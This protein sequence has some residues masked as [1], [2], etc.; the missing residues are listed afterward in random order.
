M[1]FFCFTIIIIIVFLSFFSTLFAELDEKFEYD[2]L[3][4]YSP[5]LEEVYRYPKYVTANDKIQ[6]YAKIMDK[7]SEMAKVTLFYTSDNWKTINQTQMDLFYGN[8]SSG[9]FKGEIT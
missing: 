4:K 3:K 5:S 7:F 9:I 6:I 1:I 2:D 8:L